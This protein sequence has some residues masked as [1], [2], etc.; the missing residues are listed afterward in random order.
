MF[1]LKLVINFSF[2]SK[3]KISIELKIVAMRGAPLTQIPKN[4]LL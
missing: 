4:R 2:R 1:I 3:S